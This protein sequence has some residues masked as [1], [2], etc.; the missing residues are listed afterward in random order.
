MTTTGVNSLE[1]LAGKRVL[2]FGAGGG[3]DVLGAYILYSKLKRLGSEVA[4][5]SVVWER[6]VV[7]PVPGPIPLEA[8][9]GAVKRWRSLALVDGSL[10]VVREGRRIKPQLARLLEATGLEGYYI[11]LSKG[12][13][14]V[15]EALETLL[16]EVGFDYV[17]GLDTGGDMLARGCEDGLRSP[18]ADALSLHA[19]SSFSDRT[20]VAVLGPGADGELDWMKV[21]EYV[22]NVAR[23]G[24]LVGVY[25][26]NRYEYLV[27]E[28]V[29]TVVVSEASRIPLRG[30]TGEWGEARIRGGARRVFISPVSSTVYILDPSIV[31]GWTPLPKIVAGSRSVDEARRR[32]NDHCIVTELDLEE[33]LYEYKS[34]PPDTPISV[35]EI[36]HRARQRLFLEGCRAVQC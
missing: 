11:D 13:E 19:L 24:G 9:E 16:H 31:A 21:L 5:G 17:V 4:L 1:D 2:V 23:E 18:L 10:T 22:S 3:G 14:G 30:F 20:L 29:S 35:D 25:G 12:G 33:E 28:S 34:S 36:Y 32:L 15:R 27:A 26:L 6:F 8:T 7:D